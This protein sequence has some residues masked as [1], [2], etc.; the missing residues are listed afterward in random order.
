MQGR[1]GLTLS[2]RVC[3]FPP[4]WRAKYTQRDVCALLRGRIHYAFNSN[5]HEVHNGAKAARSSRRG[6]RANL[7][8]AEPA[9][10]QQAADKYQLPGAIYLIPR[11]APRC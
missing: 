11:D 4:A 8:V 5:K 7:D 2:C 1:L 10:V 9:F 3:R 6:G